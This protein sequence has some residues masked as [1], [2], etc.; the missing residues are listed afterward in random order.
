M[1]SSCRCFQRTHISAG[2]LSRN[3]PSDFLGGATL[4]T[5]S[6][7]NRFV[8]ATHSM[9]FTICAYGSL[10]AT[11]D[12]LGSVHGRRC[13]T[14]F[15]P[16]VD[17]KRC[18]PLVLAFA[19]GPSWTHHHPSQRCYCVLWTCGMFTRIPRDIRKVEEESLLDGDDVESGACRGSGRRG[20]AAAPCPF[21][22]VPRER[23][24]LPHNI[25]KSCTSL[26]STTS[27]RTAVEHVQ[28]DTDSSSKSLSAVIGLPFL[29][30]LTQQLLLRHGTIRN[31][32]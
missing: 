11:L 18:T 27:L 21:R 5:N 30:S 2:G 8:A 4:W 23:L 28:N 25:M 31:H 12:L 32:L 22:S 10:G 29:G 13:F 3:L 7:V 26:P 19:R 14:S 17:G 16:F 9:G 6:N 24:D 15:R 20:T 1:F